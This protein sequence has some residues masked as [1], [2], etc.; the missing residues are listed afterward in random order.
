M[1]TDGRILNLNL[2]SSVTT[3]NGDVNSKVDGNRAPGATMMLNHR[4]AT[5]VATVIG[6][7]FATGTG[8]LTMTTPT[9]T[10]L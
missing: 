1:G 2:R 6:T 4:T 10:P 5:V 9:P 8:T 7:M 3:G